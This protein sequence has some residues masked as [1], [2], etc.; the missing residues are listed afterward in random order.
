[1]GKLAQYDIE[2]EEKKPTSQFIP[3]PSLYSLCSKRQQIAI[4]S[5]AGE[6]DLST[7]CPYCS[8]QL[9]TI[10]SKGITGCPECYTAFACFLFPASLTPESARGAR[11]PSA[12][13]ASIDRIRAIN[14][15]RS[16]IRVAVESE[17][18]ELAA[19]LRDEIRKLESQK[20]T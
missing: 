5:S 2:N 16:R 20:R 14:D 8:T 1:M 7:S 9:E 19:S 12:R 6:S 4:Y 11:M 10:L 3:E 13:R 15:L 17:N 18:Y